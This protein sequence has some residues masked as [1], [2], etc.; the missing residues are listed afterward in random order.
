MHR[1]LDQVHTATTRAQDPVRQALALAL[2]PVV[3]LG[4]ARFAYGSVLPAMR[5]ELDWDYRLAAVP[6]ISN[7]V[8][9]LVGAM[10][11]ARVVAKVGAIR[12][13]L[14]SVAITAVATGAT[15]LASGVDVIAVLRF[16]TGCAGAWAYVAGAVATTALRARGVRMAMVWYPAGTGVGVAVSAAI[17]LLVRDRSELWDWTWLVLGALGLVAVWIV[18]RSTCGIG[19]LDP[20]RPNAAYGGFALAGWN[21]AAGYALFGAGYIGVATFGVSYLVDDGLTTLWAQLFWIVVGGAIMVSGRWWAHWFEIAGG[22]LPL[23][24]P[25]AGCAVAAALLL[26]PV[27]TIGAMLS[28]ALLGGCL[29]NTTAGISTIIHRDLEPA[30]WGR[31]FAGVTAAFAAGQ[32]IG[33]VIAVIVGEDTDAAYSILAASAILLALGAIV[34]GLP[35]RDD[36][37]SLVDM[38]APMRGTRS[39]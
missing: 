30:A 34:A 9:Y 35:V 38:R 20:P 18:H 19:S 10:T 15:G 14:G 24:G 13:A 16:V 11:G 33:P 39:R 23:A 3:A 17:G 21:I 31:A 12:G 7:G 37:A 2:I 27:T 22:G 5:V 4:F 6:A 25:I 8:G 28:A 32:M 29:L 1:I 26:I 36:P